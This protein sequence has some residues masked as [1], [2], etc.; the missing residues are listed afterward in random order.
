M[1]LFPKCGK[2]IL[3]SFSK[4]DGKS[5]L[6]WAVSKGDRPTTLTLIIEGADVTVRDRVGG[7]N[8]L[9]WAALNE[10]TEIL[11]L[12]MTFLNI[13]CQKD[14]FKALVMPDFDGRTPLMCAY[15]A[16]NMPAIT[17]ILFFLQKN[18]LL[19]LVAMNLR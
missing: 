13:H 4:K 17:T 8:S 2:Y 3:N 16:N 5:Q 7:K 14:F 10:N 6:S 1:Q 19:V 9:H 18:E 12:L 15:E 11:E